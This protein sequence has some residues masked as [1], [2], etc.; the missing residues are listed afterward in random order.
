M[1]GE[2]KNKR[3]DPAERLA[4]IVACS[5]P[6]AEL[7]YLAYVLGEQDKAFSESLRAIPE[8]REKAAFV[9]QCILDDTCPTP[10]EWS[11]TSSDYEDEGSSIGT[12][13]D[14]HHHKT[15]CTR[16]LG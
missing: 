12:A 10:G 1:L 8:N 11:D 3:A 5:F 14:S 2:P 16:L 9:A 6:R 7:T 15:P 13:R 4:T